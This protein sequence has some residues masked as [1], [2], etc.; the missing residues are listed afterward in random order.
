MKSADNSK[1]AKPKVSCDC[2]ATA[3]SVW[4]FAGVETTVGLVLGLVVESGLVVDV[5]E[6]H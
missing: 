3:P 1:T 4:V 6:M 5:L 2:K